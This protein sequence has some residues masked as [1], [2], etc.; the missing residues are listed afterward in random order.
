MHGRR[1]RSSSNG[2]SSWRGSPSGVSLTNVGYS[3]VFSV[4]LLVYEYRQWLCFGFRVIVDDDRC[5]RFVVDTKPRL[6]TGAREKK[7]DNKKVYRARQR[8]MRQTV[9]VAARIVD[10]RLCETTSGARRTTQHG[11]VEARQARHAN[12]AARRR[13][14]GE[15]RRRRSGCAL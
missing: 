11:G 8:T 13:G 6:Q 14:R 3:V 12:D 15:R 7:N 10:K 5:E 4:M 2:A 9:V 1:A